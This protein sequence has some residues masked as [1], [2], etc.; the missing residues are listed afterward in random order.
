MLATLK[1][2]GVTPDF[3]IFHNYP[4]NPGGEDD[5]SL[6]Q[7]SEPPN[8]WAYYASD[9]RTQITD[10]IGS[11]NDTNIELVCTENNSVSSNPGKQSVSLV[12]GLY[13]VDSLGAL[14]Q[15][16]FNGLFWWALRNGQGTGGNMSSSLYGWRIYGDYGVV[17]S[18]YTD[19]YPTYYTTEL[20]KDFVQTGDTVIIASSGYSLLSAYAVR[21]QDG[22]L[23]ILAINKDPVDTLTGKITVAGFT[24]ASGATV[25]SYGIPQ[26]DAAQTGTGSP[27]I[28]QTTL[29]V[30]GTNITYAF[31]PYSATVIALSPGPATLLPVSQSASQFVI[32][33]EGQPGAPYVVQRSTNLVTWV[34]VSTNT[35]VGNT[36][37]VTNS[38]LPSVPQ[39]FWRAV[40][41]P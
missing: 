22:S 40:W 16:E 23:T 1:S 18:G 15:T 2:L 20:M 28:A 38:V 21:R 25:Y 30:S 12:N 7:T 8:G 17:D 5:A 35:P 37:T 36:I 27:G 32:Q 6:L 29:S 19:V 39:Q 3:A 41:Q 13:K 34:P 33:V 24:P 11:P 9:L 26:D 10:Y 4:E 14:M 31:S